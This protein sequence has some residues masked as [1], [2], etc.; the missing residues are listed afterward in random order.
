MGLH[1]TNWTMCTVFLQVYVSSPDS[2]FTSV[3]VHSPIRRFSRL[4]ANPELSDIAS[5]DPWCD[6]AQ[7]CRLNSRF[8]FFSQVTLAAKVDKLAAKVEMQR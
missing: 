4:Q 2:A 8:L 6:A 7:A 1:K 3:A 5:V